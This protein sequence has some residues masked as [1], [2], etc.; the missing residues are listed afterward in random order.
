[1]E[2]RQMGKTGLQVSAIGLGTNNF[3]GRLDPEATAVVVH[4]ALDAGINFIDTANIYGAG[5]SEDYIGR[6]LKDGKRSKAIVAT[7]VSGPMGEGPNRR[8][9]SRAHIMIE[10]EES[11]KRLQTDYIDLYQIHFTDPKT[12]IEE[13]M[14]ALND[15]VHQGKVRYIGCSNFAAWQVAE[16]NW[17]ARMHGLEEF[18]TVQPQYSL[19]ER[20]IEFELTPFC[21]AYNIGI[22]PYSPLA[23]G[24][25][26]G[27]Y[28]EN[29]PL[30]EG[31][32]ISSNRHAQERTLTKANYERLNKFEK[33]AKD[34]GHSMTE[35]AFAFLLANPNVCSVIAGAMNAQQVA[36]NAKAGDWRLTADEVTEVAKI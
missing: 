8:G 23:G 2:Y 30:P 36:E 25:L 14:Q 22:V 13:T 19:L 35:F 12:P 4:K 33:F 9:N 32:R 29:Q 1:M 27:K 24:F 11:L 20:R 5:K 16:A 6:A 28:H 26:T 3:G 34:R 15:L 17:T 7:K 10:V 18:V 21:K 31:T